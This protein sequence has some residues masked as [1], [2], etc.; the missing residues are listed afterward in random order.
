MRQREVGPTKEEEVSNLA[1]AFVIGTMKKEI[2]DVERQIWMGAADKVC[3]P[4]TQRKQKERHEASSY[5]QA[6]E[7]RQRYLAT[8]RARLALYQST[9]EIG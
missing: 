7:C 4:T 8:A 1:R 2:Q 3:D 6:E 5:Q 9:G